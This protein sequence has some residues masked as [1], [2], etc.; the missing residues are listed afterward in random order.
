MPSLPGI[1]WIGVVLAACALSAQAADA[2]APR[3]A[4]IVNRSIETPGATPVPTRES[5]L[6]LLE[7][8][9]ELQNQ[10]RQLQNQLEVQNNEVDKLKSRQRDIINDL[11]RRLREVERRAS[12]RAP[13][14]PVPETSAAGARLA[15]T[16]E[17]QAYDEALG[18]MKQGAYE[19]A[20]REFGAFLVKYPESGLADNAHYWIA[21]AYYIQRNYKAAMA[22]FTKVVNAYPTSPKLP[23]ALF[24]IGALHQ[25]L[26]APEQARKT[27]TDL[28]ERYPN[29]AS[30]K[31]AQK[32][33]Q[34]L[35][36]VTK[37][38]R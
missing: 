25:D 15:G 10:L 19:R 9:E 33:L 13:E 1:A 14:E 32:R 30:A 11:D 24:K 2:P 16:E 22:Q 20:V 35:D 37:K 3:R 23:D 29:N 8:M 12:A 27:W 34:E 18:L 36:K 4:P 38:A 5:L 28:S 31:L 21:E 26:G 17:Q 6:Q 7:Q